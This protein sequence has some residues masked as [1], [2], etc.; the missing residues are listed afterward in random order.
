M[1]KLLTLAMAA[2]IATLSGCASFPK[3]Q[4]PL[5]QE[6][7]D[8][9]HFRNLP[10]VYVDFDFYRGEPNN[11]PSDVDRAEP[12]LRPMIEEVMNE[13]NLFSKVS[14]SEFNKS[15]MDYTL[16][17]RI[18]NHGPVAAAAVG[19]FITGFTFGVI[20]SAATDNFTVVLEVLDN[21]NEEKSLYKSENTDA[22]TTWLGIWFIPVMN[23]TPIKAVN[24]SLEN[25]IKQ[26]LKE[27]F[28]SRTM[29]YTALQQR[30]KS[31]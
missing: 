17:L 15:N 27:A 11:S 12:D 24:A 21:N 18:Y 9:S 5:V 14:F 31:A 19:G 25:Q 20:P 13:S 16:Q 4:L 2:A 1:K 6:M 30:L 22:I 29:E 23:H 10:S 3:E 28:E 8:A 26:A 7:P